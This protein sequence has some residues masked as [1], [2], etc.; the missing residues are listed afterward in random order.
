[1]HFLVRCARS[2]MFASASASASART[3]SRIIQFTIEPRILLIIR[4]IVSGVANIQ[5]MFSGV[6]PEHSIVPMPF[7]CNVK[8]SGRMVVAAAAAAADFTQFLWFFRYALFSLSFFI[9]FTC[10]KMHKWK[11]GVNKSLAHF[12]SNWKSKSHADVA[13]DSLWIYRQN[14]MRT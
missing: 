7:I 10:W 12:L 1:M 11:S 9:H 8:H 2:L 4:C 5:L 6:N 13:I 14:T 3:I